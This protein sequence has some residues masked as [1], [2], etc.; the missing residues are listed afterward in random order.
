MVVATGP[1]QRH[2]YSGPELR[3][4]R[5]FSAACQ[6]TTSIPA[7]FRQARC[8]WSAPAPPARRL[9]RNCAHAGRRVYL[10][11]GRHRRMPRRYRGRDLIW[12]LDAM[13]LL[14]MPAEERGP[15]RSL[16]LITGALDA[17]TIDF[18]RFAAEGVTLLGRLEAASEGVISVRT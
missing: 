12:W 5:H 10:S 14:Q 17:D 18:R 3:D 11:V 16:P 8:W 6:S 15:D 7:S 13:G 2:A 9:P 1:Y 4:D